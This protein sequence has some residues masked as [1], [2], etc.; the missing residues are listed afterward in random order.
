MSLNF[1]FQIKNIF[2][3]ILLNKAMSLDDI[4]VTRNSN[5]IVDIDNLLKNFNLEK[6]KLRSHFKKKTISK[7]SNLNKFNN[8]NLLDYKLKKTEIEERSILIPLFELKSYFNTNISEIFLNHS[9]LNK[10]EINKEGYFIENNPFLIINS[11]KSSK[12]IVYGEKEEILNFFHET[13]C[14]LIYKEPKSN[15]IVVYTFLNLN[16][17]KKDFLII[18]NKEL[19]IN[20]YNSKI[21]NNILRKIKS[22]EIVFNLINLINKKLN[23]KAIKN[24]II[25][26]YNILLP[27]FN[28]ISNSLI[29]LK[30]LKVEIKPEFDILLVN[31]LYFQEETNELI[32]PSNIEEFCKIIPNDSQK[33]YILRDSCL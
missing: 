28:Y 13:I 7:D 23:I 33:E 11:I 1:I 32:S 21:G 15:K 24:D 31:K 14:L 18:I 5:W 25:E 12:V 27:S 20:Y 26:E 29:N 3:N 9:N 4:Q 16:K 6:Y 2:I 30:S 22:I 19:F 8:I 17:N 10:G